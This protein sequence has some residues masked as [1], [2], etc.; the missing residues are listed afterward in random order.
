MTI[1]GG[2]VAVAIRFDKDD[3]DNIC[4]S[5]GGVW[6]DV[7]GKNA[8]TVYIL[9]T[10]EPYPVSLMLPIRAVSQEYSRTNKCAYLGGTV[11]D[12]SE[13]T[14]EIKCRVRLSIEPKKM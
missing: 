3:G 12:N 2:S 1:F 8:E 13:L 5:V 9:Y 4:G 11:A 10:L 7:P 6:V 14:F